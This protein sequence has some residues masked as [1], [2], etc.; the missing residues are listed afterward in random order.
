MFQS[1]DGRKFGS[2]YV[3]KKRDSMHA[4]D[5]PSAKMGPKSTDKPFGQPTKGSVPKEEPRT[6]SEGEALMS[7]ANAHAE[8]NDVKANPE[9]VDAHQVVAEH[10]KAHTVHIAHDHKNKKHHVVSTHEDGHV[11]TSEHESPKEA[12]DM[13][14]NLAGTGEQP[15][16][17]NPEMEAPE[18]DGFQLPKLA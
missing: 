4:G 6:S 3:A 16:A 5:D 7:K 1:K 14:S 13:A 2:A 18:A 10:G 9:G 12:H 11:Q 17:E 15:A 8:P